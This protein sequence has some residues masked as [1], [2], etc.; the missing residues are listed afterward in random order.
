MYADRPPPILEMPIQPN[1]R[2]SCA[3]EIRRTI[4]LLLWPE[5]HQMIFPLS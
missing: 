5:P 1:M 3:R 2:V 4:F